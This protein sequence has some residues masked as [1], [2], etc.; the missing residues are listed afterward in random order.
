MLKYKKRI[1]AL[2]ICT[3]TV[4]SSPLFSAENKPVRS[5]TPRAAPIPKKASQEN[6]DKLKCLQQ[7][8]DQGDKTAQ[9]ELGIVY[10]N[11]DDLQQDFAKAAHWF[12][13]SAEQGEY[14]AITSLMLLVREPDLA[15]ATKRKI[16]TWLKAQGDQLP[17]L[18]FS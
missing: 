14:H 15:P 12:L 10:V 7:K 5:T 17:Q 8:A 3:L 4:L 16:E 1:W 11:G 18:D 6:L 13:K 2:L 9:L